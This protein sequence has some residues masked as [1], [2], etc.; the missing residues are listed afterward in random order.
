MRTL[1]G[2]DAV[3]GPT[4][5]TQPALLSVQPV[6]EEVVVRRWRS[7]VRPE[8]VVTDERYDLPVLKWADAYPHVYKIASGTRSRVF[9]RNSC[10]HIGWAQ[11]SKAPAAVFE[12]VRTLYDALHDPLRGQGIFR[13][14][15]RFTFEH[16]EDKGFTGGVFFTVTE[17]SWGYGDL[18]TMDYTPA[19]IADVARRFAVWARNHPQPVAVVVKK[20][21]W[22]GAA[23]HQWD[24]EKLACSS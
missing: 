7:Q 21:G 19:L 8:I 14:R 17:T 10:A 18:L 5:T 16:Y 24:W 20:K 1:P 22:K 23:V 13:W 12:R 15:A 3:S 2:S 6:C 9:G 4:V 11:R